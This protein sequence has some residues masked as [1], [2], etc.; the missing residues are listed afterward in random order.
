MRLI[1]AFL[2][3]LLGLA[4]ESFADEVV[5][6]RIG[7]GALY[8]LVRP[9]NWNGSLVVYAHGFVGSGPVALPGEGDLIIGLLAPQ[10]FAV[11][12]S[13]FSENGWNVKD[14]AQRT[15]QL[16]GLFTSKFGSPSRVY[17]G[18]I[19]MGGLIA[20]KLAEDHPNAF[21][22]VLSACAV[23][24]GSRRQ[25]DYHGNARA[26]FD[27]FYPEVLPGS[28]GD[29]PP[30]ID[31]AQAIIL[32]AGAAI[33]ANPAG[34]LAIA[35]ITQTPLPFLTSAELVNS[36]VAALASHAAQFADLIA[37]THGH[38]FFDNRDTQYAG[39]LPPSLL[40]GIN[41]GIERFAA[42]PDAAKHFNHYYEPSGDLRMPMMMLSTS[43]DPLVPAFHQDSY[44]KA[45]AENGSSDLL[46]RRTIDRYG[47]CVFTPAE[48]GSAIA[49]LVVWVEFGIK[50][51]P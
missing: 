28:A 37:R 17:V 38:P 19:S 51:A 8:R 45:V 29:V 49:D 40:E 33:S 6:G 31:T 2:I 35:G 1:A 26:L 16:L 9:T 25:F 46:V 21:S 47:H 30:D 50:P 14:G 3:L 24:G 5:D 32:P 11:A 13:S 22:G 7:P 27:F 20:I 41:A 39:A 48:L 10:G 36:L 18:G 12:F 15:F 23:A 34:A 4:G 43:R 44:E 42:T